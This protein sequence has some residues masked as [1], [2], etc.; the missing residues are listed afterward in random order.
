M[1]F[2]GDVLDDDFFVGVVV[3]ED[4]FV[5]EFGVDDCFDKVCV[6]DVFFFWCF[7]V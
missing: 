1:G 3:D 6:V 5:L 7:G 2:G 4:V